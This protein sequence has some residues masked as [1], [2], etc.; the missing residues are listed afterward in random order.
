[1][2][3]D[4]LGRDVMARVMVGGRI[5]LSVGLT[6]ALLGIFIGTAIGILAGYF[7]RLDALLMRFTDLFL[8][9]PILPL[10][11]VIILLFRDTLREQFGP[12]LGIF[13]KAG[14]ANGQGT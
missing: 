4:N 10:L 13:Q 5:S 3:T 14:R 7:R 6:A 8:A 2:G 9:I 12:E 11:L 1:M